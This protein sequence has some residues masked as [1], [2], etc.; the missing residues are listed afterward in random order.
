MGGDRSDRK[1]FRKESRD[2]TPKNFGS[3]SNGG[4]D[5]IKK[6]LETVNTKLERL[7]NSVENLAKILAP[8]KNN[9]V[10]NTVKV[11]SKETLGEMVEEV[12]GKKTPG[13]IEAK[14]ISKKVSKKK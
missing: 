11:E 6:Q 7:I 12:S 13:K 14:M 4:N 8:T 1:D 5:D 9:I 2:F 10:K 3:P